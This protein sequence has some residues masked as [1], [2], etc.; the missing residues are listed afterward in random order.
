MSVADIANGLVA[1]CRE[2]KNLEAVNKYYADDIVS[3]ESA[4][5]P[6]MPAE[7]TGIK[8]V[9]GKNEWWLANH[10]VHSRR[11]N[12][13]RRQNQIAFIFAIFIIHQ[14]NHLAGLEVFDNFRD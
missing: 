13:L 8:A 14:H 12:L 2:G 4:S 9:R 11:R 10:E 6:G 5:G 1:L 3:V 7:M